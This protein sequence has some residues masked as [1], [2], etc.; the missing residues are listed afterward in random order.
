[1]SPEMRVSIPYAGTFCAF[2]KRNAWAVVCAARFHVFA[3]SQLPRYVTTGIRVQL[4]PELP[5][6]M[7]EMAFAESSKWGLSACVGASQVLYLVKGVRFRVRFQDQEKELTWVGMRDELEFTMPP[8]YDKGQAPHADDD[9][10][11]D[12]L[13]EVI[14]VDLL[15]GIG[16]R[17]SNVR[18]CAKVR[19]HRE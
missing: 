19:P 2:P 11:R 17:A 10:R 16:A 15:E 5:N 8:A 3:M 12:V 9:D 13:S 6:Q 7:E 18:A 1:M 4:C 14:V